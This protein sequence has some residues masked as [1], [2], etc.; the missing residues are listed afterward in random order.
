MQHLHSLHPIKELINK[1][2]DSAHKAKASLW[3]VSLFLHHQPASTTPIFNHVLEILFQP[4]TQCTYVFNFNQAV[5]IWR[6]HTFR[7]RWY[8]VKIKGK[9]L[10]RLGPISADLV[11][12]ST[13]TKWKLRLSVTVLTC[14][15]RFNVQKHHCKGTEWELVGDCC[16]A[17]R[18]LAVCKSGFSCLWNSCFKVMHLQLAAVF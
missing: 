8:I 7:W 18:L 4:L 15:R 5:F 11:T 13:S 17:K 2:Q 6:L 14:W 9:T 10:V 3:P 1:F 16:A 12:L